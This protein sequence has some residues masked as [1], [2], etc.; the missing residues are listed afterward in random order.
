[1]AEDNGG[2]IRFAASEEEQDGVEPPA[3]NDSD[4]EP[5]VPP[6]AEEEM[7]GEEDDQVSESELDVAGVAAGLRATK[8]TQR[9]SNVTQKGSSKKKKKKGP[10]RGSIKMRTRSVSRSLP[11]AS[12]ASV[13]AEQVAKNNQAY[14]EKFPNWMMPLKEVPA[15]SHAQAAVDEEV[16]WP[17]E[18]SARR[19]LLKDQ[20]DALSELLTV[21]AVEQLIGAGKL[22]QELAREWGAILEAKKKAVPFNL[23]AHGLG[24]EY[25]NPETPPAPRTD[26]VQVLGVL[27][28]T[29]AAIAHFKGWYEAGFKHDCVMEHDLLTP[30]LY[31][32][33]KYREEYAEY[34]GIELG[35][36]SISTG[37]A[38]TAT[39]PSK[40]KKP[41]PKKKDYEPYP[42]GR[43]FAVAEDKEEEEEDS[44]PSPKKPKGKLMSGAVLFA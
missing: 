6:A 39:T 44:K 26:K 20:A 1:M 16:M 36:K 5:Y 40:R 31:Y 13:T 11:S 4:G 8:A 10:V 23:I 15:W 22:T 9:R 34:R 3:A 42:A 38:I 37:K 41:E 35:C 33:G 25:E 12:V 14:A 30:L 7:E 17:A 27:F 28:P 18:V 29:Q 43:L 32:Y 19:P 21:S 24:G 2:H